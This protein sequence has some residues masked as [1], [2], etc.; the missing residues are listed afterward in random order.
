MAAAKDNTI[1]RSACPFL[2]QHVIKMES[3][4]Q[5]ESS[6]KPIRL[7]LQNCAPGM[8]LEQNPVF[9]WQ[10]G[11]CDAGQRQRARRL[12]ITRGHETVYDSGVEH[13]AC[14]NDWEVPLVLETHTAY[15]AVVEAE[16]ENGEWQLRPH[17]SAL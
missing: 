15:T 1:F 5:E 4:K 10:Y 16:N 17:R 7:K 6:M 8:G 3:R 2:P 13:T 11:D 9:C 14:Q 12:T